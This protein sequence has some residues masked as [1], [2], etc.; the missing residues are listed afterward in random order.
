[1]FDIEKMRAK[2][3]DA[4]SIEIMKSVN[5]NTAKREACF[6][7]EFEQADKPFR[8]RCKNCGCVEDGRFT[9]AYKQGLEHGEFQSDQRNKPEK[10]IRVSNNRT[11]GCVR[12]GTEFYEKYN[13]CPGC[14]QKQDWGD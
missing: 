9:L 5:E 3:I 14:G 6:L 11:D 4:K 13:Y 8:Y 2:G 7:H 12:C 10:P 1:M